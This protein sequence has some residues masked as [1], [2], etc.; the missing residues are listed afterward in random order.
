MHISSLIPVLILS[1]FVFGTCNKSIEI[2]SCI[3]TQIES[4][5]QSSLCDKTATVKQY[6]FL[7]KTVYVFDEGGCCCDR[8]AS[9]VDEN[10]NSLGIL[11]GIAGITKI[12]GVVFSDSAVY[13][14]TIWHN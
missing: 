9:V 6:E 1:G 4:F 7:G 11:G 8:A 12:N 2:P 13:R 10:C 5:K 14:R 3:Q